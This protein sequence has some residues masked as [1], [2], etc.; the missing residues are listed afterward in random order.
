MR[1]VYA[2]LL[3]TTIAS[4]GTEASA[5]TP[6]PVLGAIPAHSAVK[7]SHYYVGPEYPARGMGWWGDAARR[8]RGYGPLGTGAYRGMTYGFN[9]Y[10]APYRAYSFGYP[11]NVLGPRNV[12]N[13][14]IYYTYFGEGYPG[15]K[16]WPGRTGQTW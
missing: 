5:G 4:C 2:L 11:G 8:W 7:R 9:G 16:F 1:V 13:G 10:P 3:T 6:P 14:Y 12:G 15:W